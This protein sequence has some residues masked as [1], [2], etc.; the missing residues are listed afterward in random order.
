MEFLRS[1]WKEQRPQKS[2]FK[3]RPPTQLLP[4]MPFL[5]KQTDVCQ[6]GALRIFGEGEGLQQA[7]QL[8]RCPSWKDW[9]RLSSGN[10]QAKENKLGG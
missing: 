7:S 10:C 5:L 9:V 4:F 6:P 1:H 3:P 2:A 8:A